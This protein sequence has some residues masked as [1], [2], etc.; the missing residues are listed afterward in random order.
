LQSMSDFVMD[1]MV[2]NEADVKLSGVV[3]VCRQTVQGTCGA[4]AADTATQVVA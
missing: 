2:L 4:S 1:A 3:G